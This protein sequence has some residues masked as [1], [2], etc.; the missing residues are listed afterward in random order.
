MALDTHVGLPKKWANPEILKWA[1]T[2]VGL[3]PQDVESLAG[4]RADR[5]RDWE[6][7]KGAPELSDLQDLAE[8]YDC[9][10]G[11]FFLDLPPQEKQVL[12]FRGLA[13]EKVDGLSYESHVHLSEFLRLTDY[14]ASLLEDLNLPHKVDIDD[15]DVDERLESVASRETEKL[16]FTPEI[17][18]Q[19]TTANEAFGFWRQAIESRGVF[20]LALKLKTNEVRGASRW[21]SPQVPAILV[22][23]SDMEAAT[24]R[25]FTLLHEWAHLL[26]KQPGLVCDFRGQA[27]GAKLERFAN[28]FAS[29]ILVPRKE[30][31]V[32]LKNRNLYQKRARW[33]D[34]LLDDIRQEFKVS[35][36]VIA[37]SLEETELA[38]K[39]FYSDKRAS[40][41]LRRPF[42]V[43]LTGT[44]RGRTKSV[45]RLSEIGHPMANLLSVAYE[46]GVIPKLH[47]AE[48]LDMKVEQAEKFVSWVRENPRG[49]SAI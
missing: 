9:P 2:R 39:G 23:R 44:R 28:Q 10:V 34:S 24:G 11:Y 43:G 13:A 27:K 42:F 12:D 15:I 30:F 25:T 19:W 40:W 38:P 46:R 36:D 29:E 6:H 1:R 16:G 18:R 33:G 49:D 41:D 35:R 14:L 8:T 47:L 5:I 31:Q 20:V 45:I 32:Y 26:V 7:A 22:N 21:E 37:I 48:I 4:I 17:R 3:H